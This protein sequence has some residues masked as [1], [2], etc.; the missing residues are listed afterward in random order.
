MWNQK[1]TQIHAK[2]VR[3]DIKRLLQTFL[4]QECSSQIEMENAT[5]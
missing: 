3:T 2:V 1:K 4:C 5:F